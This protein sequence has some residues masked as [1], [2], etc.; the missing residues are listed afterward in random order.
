VEYGYSYF[1]TQGSEIL[2]RSSWDGSDRVFFSFW[3]VLLLKH[4]SCNRVEKRVFNVYKGLQKPLVFKG[5]KG[6]FI[7]WGIASVVSS[8]IIGGVV[9]TLVNGILGAVAMIICII[10]GYLLTAIQQKKGLHNKSRSRG[11]FIVPNNWD[12]GYK[13]K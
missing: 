8:L 2:I 7:Y 4:F 12:Y 5:F 3:L 13:K 11:I 10:V 9:G 1:G 6:K